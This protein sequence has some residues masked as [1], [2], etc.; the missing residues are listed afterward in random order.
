[1]PLK[2]IL[3]C[4]CLA[5]LFINGQAQQQSVPPDPVLQHTNQQK[6][7]EL[8]SKWEKEAKQDFKKARNFARKHNMPIQQKFSD[9]TFIEIQG[10]GP[11]GL[12]HYSMTHNKD[13]AETIST[14]Q[15]NPSGNTGFNLDGSGMTIGIWDGNAVLSSHQEFGN[16]ATQ[17]DNETTTSDHAT[18]VA[19]TMVGAGIQNQAKGMAFNASL[20]AYDWYLDE[21]EMA[22]AASNGL[23]ISNHS[24]SKIIGF[25]YNSDSNQ[26]EWRGDP[27]IS[28]NEDYRFGF[29]NSEAKNWDQIAKNAP[30]YLIVRSAGND[31]NDDGPSA[32]DPHYVRNNQ[33]QWVK[34]TANRDPDGN[35]DCLAPKST[36]KNVLT[37]GAVE[38]ITGGYQNPSDVTMT[39]FS[40]WGPTDDGRIKPEIVANGYQLYSA[41][42]QSNNAYTT[43]TGTSMSSP[44][45]AGS[46]LLL[47]ELYQDSVSNTPLRGASLKALAIHSADEAG[48]SPG[49]DYK[50]GYGLMNTEKAADVINKEGNKALIEEFD[51]QNNTQ[52]TFK[53]TATG[54]EPLKATI[55]WN[56][57]PGNPPSPSLD[58]TNKMLVNDLDLRIIDP[59]NNATSP[60][61]M[62]PSN[63]SAPAIRGD[64]TR[65]NV[66]QVLIDNP[67]QGSTY[68]IKIDHKNQLQQQQNQPV[69][70]IVTGIA[71]EV[72]QTFC[73]DTVKLQSNVG[74]VEDGSQNELYGNNADCYW[75]IQT[76]NGEALNL[77]F[78]EFST[79]QGGDSLYIYEGSSTSGQLIGSFTGSQAPD[80]LATNHNEIFLHFTTNN[81]LRD[82]GWKIRF[83][84]YDQNACG[85]PFF[86]DYLSEDTAETGY[87]FQ[88]NTGFN[89]NNV[90][91]A[92]QVKEIGTA[93][94]DWV[95]TNKGEFSP[96]FPIKLDSVLT[97][98]T[99]E[100][101]SGLNDTFQVYIRGLDSNN[102]PSGPILWQENLI[103]QQTLS[104]SGDWNS[105]Q[106][107]LKTLTF[108]PNLVIDAPFFFGMR[109]KAPLE[110]TASILAYHENLGTQQ[111]PKATEANYGIA[112]RKHP[113]YSS[114][115]LPQRDGTE[116]L[117]HDNNNNGNYDRGTNEAHFMQLLGFTPVVTE[118]YR[119]DT[120]KIKVDTNNDGTF[121]MKPDQ[122]FPAYQWFKDGNPI[123]EAN[124]DTLLV[125]DNG[126]FSLA[127]FDE[128]DCS[129]FSDTI[130]LTCPE[131]NAEF[132]ATQDNLKIQLTNN[133]TNGEKIK[134][135]LGDST[136]D[137]ASNP[138]HEFPETG[139]YK[140][141]LEVIN[142][143][144][145][146][147]TC[148]TFDLKSTY[149]LT[150]S[151]EGFIKIYPNPSNGAFQWS[152]EGIKDKEIQIQVKDVKGKVVSRTNKTRQEDSPEFTGELDLGHL[153]KGN[154][155]LEIIHDKGKH[156]QKLILQ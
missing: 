102:Y 90:N 21:S 30:Y 40:S 11:D 35:Y 83:S 28:P 78:L 133:A 34:S 98:I 31:R 53:V 105:G 128:N 125:Q 56:D 138:I 38:D 74:I 131:V 77:D 41:N 152:L 63:Q 5:I 101:N 49:P 17:A 55:C 135:Y 68:T 156:T 100:N 24:Y 94:T 14:D 60:W 9:G 113:A 43:K 45:V 99:H 140:V 145:Y 136:T 39:S 73:Q 32:G 29:Y 1:M 87:I 112:Y 139:T 130:S 155:F 66:E 25:R 26:W 150:D 86:M 110:D 7:L 85:D 16:R 72:A 75:H 42:D 15:V 111:D 57:E 154:Y 61:V 103:T 65:D 120:P 132:S 119:L 82:E 12:P 143:C 96:N 117:F 151:K 95:S 27:S 80:S 44:S 13:A 3:T 4:L 104:P 23:L 6:L 48:S 33:G 54:N 20:D 88:M 124:N 52:K 146:D 79:E 19:G 141:C 106:E 107:V 116:L 76:Q 64:N 58:P 109:Y 71:D 47:Q 147:S 70:L 69:S 134:W 144:D 10:M 122:N 123:N 118:P 37:V 81:Q 153:S 84:G 114:N 67:Q 51:L 92:Y 129:S 149:N 121:T 8:A 46:L 115:W 97:Y 137:T 36:A 142:E 93:F 91:R 59:T 89:Q 62:I 50:Y 148:Q 108:E 18:H 127:V 22:T 2:Y 126:A